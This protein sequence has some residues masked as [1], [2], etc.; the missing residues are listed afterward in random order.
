MQLLKISYNHSLNQNYLTLIFILPTF[1][2]GEHF[3]QQNFFPFFSLN[4]SYFQMNINEQ[5]ILPQYEN[6]TTVQSLSIWH[7]IPAFVEGQKRF[8]VPFSTYSAILYS[9]L[10]IWLL[11]THNGYKP[12]KK[13]WIITWKNFPNIIPSPA[14]YDEVFSPNPPH[15]L[16]MCNTKSSAKYL[17]ST[18]FISVICPLLFSEV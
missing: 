8:I 12:K 7:S 4:I 1:Q 16:C 13:C 15:I 10:I 2:T 18:M 6:M 17:T 9:D 5:C 11:L 3:Q 14:A